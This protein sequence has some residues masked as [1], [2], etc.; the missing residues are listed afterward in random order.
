MIIQLDTEEWC[1]KNIKCLHFHNYIII[2]MREEKLLHVKWKYYNNCCIQ[3][4]STA[5]HIH[6]YVSHMVILNLNLTVCWCCMAKCLVKCVHVLCVCVVC[7]YF[8][9]SEWRLQ[10]GFASGWFWDALRPL[11]SHLSCLTSHWSLLLTSIGLLF[12]TMQNWLS[13]LK[14]RFS[15]EI[16]KSGTQVFLYSLSQVARVWEVCANGPHDDPCFMGLNWGVWVGR[17]G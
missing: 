1:R 5:Y 3:W 6:C 15:L 16:M 8:V 4:K 13:L 11:L 9:C 7:V 14:S 12:C 10:W 2:F 17:C